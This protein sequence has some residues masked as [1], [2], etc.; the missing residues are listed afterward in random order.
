MNNNQGKLNVDQKRDGTED[1]PQGWS[2]RG[3][4]YGMKTVRSPQLTVCYIFN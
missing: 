2:H 3:T 4:F 1:V